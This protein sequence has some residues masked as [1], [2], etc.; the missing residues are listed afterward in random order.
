VA[1]R[2]AV[3]PSTCRRVGGRHPV[4]GVHG[5]SDAP[6]CLHPFL[7]ALGAVDAVTPALLAHDGRP[8]PAG[9]PFCD[10]VLVADTRQAVADV[11]RS[12]GAPVVLLGHSLGASTAAGVAATAPELVCALVLEDPPWQVPAS[13]DG[14]SGLD[15][16]AEAE[17]EHGPW[18]VGLA[19]TDDEGRRGWIREH[20]PSWPD[21]EHAPWADAK[22]AVDL[23]LFDAPQ[24]WLRR[25][26]R[27]IAAAVD[28]PTLLLVG[29]ADHDT[30]CAAEVSSELARLPGWTVVVVPGAGHNVRRDQ[31]DLTV[32]EVTRFLRRSLRD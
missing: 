3:S 28:C 8:M 16:A 24:R 31:R 11:V 29:E 5:F 10:D 26:W 9:V 20:H 7:T 25:R 19:G 2:H 27:G 22:A 23:R 15:R 1:G 6:A 12:R 32:A 4:V 13:P 14:T 30:A 21:D 17:N 18:L